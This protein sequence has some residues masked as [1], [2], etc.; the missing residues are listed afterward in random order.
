MKFRETYTELSV[1]RQVQLVFLL[2]AFILCG[3]LVVITK[4]Q[5]DWIRDLTISE[6]S[7]A[8]KNRI[9]HQIENIGEVEAS[10]FESEF[11][12]YEYFTLNLAKTDEIINGFSKDYNSKVFQE[13]KSYSQDS[14]KGTVDYSHG[15]Y[16]TKYSSLSPEGQSL[17]K[18][19]SSFNFIYSALYTN[20]FYNY[21]QGYFTDELTNSYPSRKITPGYSPLPRE[22]F[23]RGVD[24]EGQVVITEPYK[25]VDQGTWVVSLSKAVMKNKKVFGVAACDVTLEVLTEKI[26]KVKILE[27]GFSILVSATGIVLTIP[28]QWVNN[29]EDSLRIFDS[30]ITGISYETWVEIRDKSDA[31]WTSVTIEEDEDLGIEAADLKIFKKNI[32][33]MFQ[34]NVTHYLLLVVDEVDT[35]DV[36]DNMIDQFEKTYEILFWVILAFGIT[37]VVLILL[38]SF[39]FGRELTKHFSVAEEILGGLLRRGFFTQRNKLFD[40]VFPNKGLMDIENFKTAVSE[41]VIQLEKKENKFEHQTWFNT[42]PEDNLFYIEWAQQLYPKFKVPVQVEYWDQ[43][44][45][46]IMSVYK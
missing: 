25:D 18:N 36:R 45:E 44:I 41:K 5:L 19:E 2:T 7:R 9:Y 24:N 27:N 23:Y 13:S 39:F 16:Y 17:V 20:Y 40:H 8:F 22:W 30:S 46:R 31:S 37:V 29:D 34:S 32:V 43:K 38:L 35:D 14:A 12:G 6:A 42:R 3:I 1:A 10:Y 11:T 21:Y 15:V 26:N 4:F 33:P 28:D